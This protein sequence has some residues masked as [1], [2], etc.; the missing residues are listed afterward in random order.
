MKRNAAKFI[1]VVCGIIF[2]M[3]GSDNPGAIPSTTVDGSPSEWRSLDAERYNDPKGDSSGADIAVL[4]VIRQGD[5]FHILM[6]FHNGIDYNP[7][8]RYF[9]NINTDDDDVSDFQVAISHGSRGDTCRFKKDWSTYAYRTIDNAPG[10]KAA[11]GEAVE[12]QVPV[13]M[14]NG[15]NAFGFWAGV[16]DTAKGVPADTIGGYYTKLKIHY[17]LTVA[18]PEKHLAR[19]DVKFTDCPDTHLNLHFPPNYPEAGEIRIEGVKATG[20]DGGPLKISHKKGTYTINLGKSTK[21]FSL[22]YMLSMNQYHDFPVRGPAGYL[23]KSYML[24]STCWS[25]ISPV[26]AD[27]REYTLSLNL[28][29]GWAPVV[30]WKKA[31]SDY[32]ETDAALFK[33]T[34]FGAG[35]F[36]IR[37]MEIAGTEVTVAIDAHFDEKFR[38][39][40]FKNS[41]MSFAF[42]KSAFDAGVP[43]THLAIFA[44]PGRI[45]RMAVLQRERA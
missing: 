5:F 3:A 45:G 41:A 4:S 22:S 8:L 17:T 36:D 18:D 42:I 12:F 11:M 15:R 14:F 43:G 9:I 20:Q 28:P 32:V 27:A 13:S 10:F 26:K 34:T 21:D 39:D 2:F 44:K 38:K 35:M 6:T 23:C 33:E 30:P 29:E 40:L 37:K 7:A 24:T 19:I 31:G 25:L 1:I 16:W